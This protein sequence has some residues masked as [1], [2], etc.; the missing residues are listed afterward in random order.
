ML[1]PG[2]QQ[3]NPR[4]AQPLAGRGLVAGRGAM[5]RGGRNGGRWPL[6]RAGGRGVEYSGSLGNYAVGGTTGGFD[7][8]QGFA[9]SVNQVATLPYTFFWHRVVLCFCSQSGSDAQPG[10]IVRLLEILASDGSTVTPATI[11]RFTP[12]S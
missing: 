8:N 2:T 11:G 7:L 10:N 6:G 12:Y 1:T 3:V 9:P 5:L 4:T